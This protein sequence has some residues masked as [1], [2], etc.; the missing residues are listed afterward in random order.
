MHPALATA[1]DRI[2]AREGREPTALPPLYEAVDPEAVT[3]LLESP[4]A[5]T[6]R[7]AYA[8]YVVVIGP[9]PL[10]VEVIDEDR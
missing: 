10:E 1:F 5:V 3:A 2:A 7:F 4:A 9:D 6:V 8:G